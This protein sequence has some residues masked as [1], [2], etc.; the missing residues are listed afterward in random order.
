MVW[1]E[2][3]GGLK[4][5]ISVGLLTKRPIS[6]KV[7][8][9]RSLR[10]TRNRLG[11]ALMLFVLSSASAAH[12]MWLVAGVSGAEGKIC[13]RI[14]ERF[15]DTVNAPTAD[16]VTAFQ[17]RFPDRTEK[18]AGTFLDKQFCAPSPADKNGIIEMIVQP[19]LNRID[20][21]RF[22][23]F[24]RGEGLQHVI[25]QPEADAASDVTYLYSRYSKLILGAP[26]F[27]MLSEPIGHVLEIVPLNDPSALP[28]GS[29]FR[30]RVM[31]RGRP[32]AN[33]QIAAVHEGAS[34]EAHQFPVV[35]RT[36]KD[37]IA[38][39]KLTRQGLWYA[40][41][42]HTIRANDP[43]FEWHHFFATMTFH[44]AQA[45]ASK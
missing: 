17:A 14:G 27:K 22:G 11:P 38:E 1:R 39:L 5:K 35:T 43:E 6:I 26:T 16:R 21:K 20:R 44:A 30:V 36:D 24:V 12:D 23:E 13:A 10:G 8:A 4:V 18:L 25:A 45:S 3:Q 7:F 32:L 34:P 42:I 29:S 31:F 15:P 19:R 28:Q 2:G 33:A 40:R 9:M 37:G 41:L